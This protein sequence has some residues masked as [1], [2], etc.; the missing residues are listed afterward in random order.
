MP[1]DTYVEVQRRMGVKFTSIKCWGSVFLGVI[2][3]I[4]L[5]TDEQKVRPQQERHKLNSQKSRLAPG[6]GIRWRMSL[7][8]SED[9]SEGGSEHLLGWQDLG[10][11][12]WVGSSCPA[13]NCSRAQPGQNLKDTVHV[14]CLKKKK[15][16]YCR[17]SNFVIPF[18]HRHF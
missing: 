1:L 2:L 15:I 8:A 7:G 5:S 13:S 10:V 16:G 14:F 17:N 9:G 18:L 12:D 6:D 3:S 11:T 4:S